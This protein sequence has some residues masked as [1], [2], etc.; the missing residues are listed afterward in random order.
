[1]ILM[2]CMSAKL[3]LYVYRSNLF[4]LHIWH[5]NFIINGSKNQENSYTHA[6]LL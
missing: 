2:I 6:F 3:K 5:N 4:E 1:M